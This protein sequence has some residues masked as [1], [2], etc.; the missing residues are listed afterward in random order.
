[1]ESETKFRAMYISVEELWRLSNAV[2]PVEEALGNTVWIVGS[3]LTKENYRDVDLRVILDDDEYNRLFMPNYKDVD[4]TVV[5]LT[6]QFRMLIQTAISAMLRQ[7]TNLPI[8]FQIQSQTEANQYRGKR[9]PACMRPY[10]NPEFRPR[11]KN[12]Q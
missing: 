8:D 2:R 1:M 9:N 3:V 7:T 6:D 5:G 12:E 11:W 4:G 10:I